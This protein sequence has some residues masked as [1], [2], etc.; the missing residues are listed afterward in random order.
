MQITCLYCNQW[1][2]SKIIGV[3][4]STQSNKKNKDEILNLKYCRRKKKNITSEVEA[5]IKFRPNNYFYCIKKNQ[6]LALIVCMYRRNYIKH[7]KYNLH[8]NC[9]KCIT[10]N[11]II[12][13][14]CERF[15]ISPPKILQ[16]KRCKIHFKLKLKRRNKT[17]TIIRRRNK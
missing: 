15:N 17:L 12:K 11:K 2:Q 4:Q 3:T 8:K 14:I 16:L 7:G 10:Y 6:R 1:Q 9:D 5:C 13:P